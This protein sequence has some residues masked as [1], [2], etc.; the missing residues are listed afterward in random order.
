M[1]VP[2]L[3][4]IDYSDEHWYITQQDVC[5]NG[6]EFFVDEGTTPTWEELKE[7]CRPK[8]FTV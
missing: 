3:K 4:Y 7:M 8:E 1:M 6:W 5:E 2:E